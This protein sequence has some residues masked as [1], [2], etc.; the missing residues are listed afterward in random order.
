VGGGPVF[1]LIAVVKW[2]N[3]LIIMDNSS[4]PSNLL[5]SQNL[6]GRHSSSI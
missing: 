4:F 5:A 1:R 6:P 2:R 3:H